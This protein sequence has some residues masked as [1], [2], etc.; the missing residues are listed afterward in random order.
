MQ[1]LGLNP[2]YERHLTIADLVARKQMAVLHVMEPV[3]GTKIQHAIAL[4]DIDPIKE[5]V[6]VANPLYGIQEKKFSDLKDYW[7][8]D[9]IFITTSKK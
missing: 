1:Q 2:N 3:S 6:T 7:L 8:E 4:L 5:K 9:A